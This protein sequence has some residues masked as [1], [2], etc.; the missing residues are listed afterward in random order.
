M[1]P[2]HTNRGFTIL[3]LVAI[4][5]SLVIGYVAAV[6]QLGQARDQARELKDSTQ[7]RGITQA[8]AIWAQNNRE[9]YPIPSRID[10][11]GSTIAR[12]DGLVGRDLRLDTTGNTLCLLIWNGFLPPELAVSPN[13][14]GNVEVMAN[15]NS[16]APQSA[17][18]PRDAFWDPA[19]RGTPLDEWGGKVP[20]AV[21][22]ASHNS[23]AQMAYHGAREAVWSNT[24]S[25][26]EACWGN[27]GPAYTLDRG[28]WTPLA[29]SP[30]GDG[31]TTLRIHGAPETWEGNIAFN[32]QHVEFLD[33]PDPMHLSWVF[34]GLEDQLNRRHPDNV[35]HS[36][37]DHD[38]TVIDENIALVA[39]NDGRGSLK[40]T[41]KP[42]GKG[43]LDQKN[44]YLRPISKVVPGEN[45]TI[46]TQFWID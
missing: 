12:P 27:R 11:N 44:N 34:P 40:A 33:R 25:S 1:R 14:V 45:G 29:G 43:A 16:A 32:D 13:E 17:M 5:A 20:G 36:E 30:F 35:F 28:V 9:R 39:G 24:F 15:F 22:D 26:A 6:P 23:Y 7:L 10:L 4:I 21:G 41:G 18:R 42:G 2:N 19:F 38:R 46:E 31:S 3:E 37:N 8:C